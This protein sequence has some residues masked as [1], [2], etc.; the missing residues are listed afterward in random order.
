MLL[1]PEGTAGFLIADRADTGETSVP[2]DDRVLVMPLLGVDVGVEAL[3]GVRA[4]F[5]AGE[6]VGFV[7]GRRP[8]EVVPGGA[9]FLIAPDIVK[10]PGH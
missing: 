3:E 7:D 10:R 5:T 9:G 8:L 4:E 6:V 2:L 1:K